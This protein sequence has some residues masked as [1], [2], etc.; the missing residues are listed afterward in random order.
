[1][2]SSKLSRRA[3]L[4]LMWAAP[5]ALLPA[6]TVLVTD[7]H[8]K[9]APVVAASGSRPVI[10]DHGRRAFASGERFALVKTREFLP[11]FVAVRNVRVRTSYLQMDGAGAINN[12][13]HFHAN[14]SS[15]YPLKDVFAVF[16]MHSDRGDRNLFLYELGQMEPNDPRE[17]DLTVPTGFRVGSGH[18]RLHI[19]SGGME[20]RNSQQP[21]DFREAALNRIVA[22]HLK[23]RRDGPP[24]PFIGPPPE[25]PAKLAKAGV[26]GRAVVHLRILPN[27]AVVDPEVRSATDPAFGESAIAALRQWR[28]FPE[29]KNGRPVTAAVSLPLDFV[30]PRK[31]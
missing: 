27:G 18:F 20:V 17:I 7:Y 29:I 10:D 14:F 25:Y 31:R 2:I 26:R 5:A 1:M 3:A 6:Q 12:E 28:F 24:E 9:P 11:V 23:G 15:A 4:A 30:P 13:F 19:Y 8:G 22:D 21:F 16:E